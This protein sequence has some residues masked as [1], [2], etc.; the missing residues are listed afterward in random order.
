MLDTGT[1]HSGLARERISYGRETAY[2]ET[3]ALLYWNNAPIKGKNIHE[4]HKKETW[5]WSV[6]LEAVLLYSKQ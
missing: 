5:I 3:Y 6:I 4:V 1:H 2:S